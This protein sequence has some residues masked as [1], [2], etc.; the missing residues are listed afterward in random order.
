[1]LSIFLEK[2]VSFVFGVSTSSG[3]GEFPVEDDVQLKG[4][5]VDEV[6]E[7]ANSAAG[8]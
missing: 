8:S 4:P 2:P 5:P 3:F 7:L 1:M 6:L